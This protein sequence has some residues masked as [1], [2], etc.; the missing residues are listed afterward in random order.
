[1]ENIHGAQIRGGIREV[2]SARGQRSQ[3]VTE[4]TLRSHTVRRQIKQYVCSRGTFFFSCQNSFKTT[5]TT[6][7]SKDQGWDIAL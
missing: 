4:M 3:T 1:M 6:T 5:T 2:K 7:T